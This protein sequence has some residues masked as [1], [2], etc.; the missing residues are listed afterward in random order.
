MAD[1]VAVEMA[2]SLAG[3]GGG[4]TTHWVVDTNAGTD[5]VSGEIYGSVY[6]R[7]TSRARAIAIAEWLNTPAP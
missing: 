6:C 2:A 3:D 1:Y 4:E 7:V 5:S